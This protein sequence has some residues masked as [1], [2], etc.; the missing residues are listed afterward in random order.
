M[1]RATMS[2][3]ISR[4]RRMV[5]DTGTPNFSDDAIQDELDT[6]QTVVLYERLSTAPTM[7]NGVAQYLTFGSAYQ[8]FETGA[9]VYN[10]SYGVVTPTTANLIAGT[11]TFS[12]NQDSTMYVS[13]NA[14]NVFGAAANLCDQWAAQLS[15]S[16]DV[17]DG[18][19]EMKRSQMAKSLRDQ[20][21]QY[22]ASQGIL[23]STSERSDVRADA[24][25]YVAMENFY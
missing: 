19:S 13:G 15:R 3:L 17:K 1:P 12:S 22:R 6:F 2:A 5:G 9:V 7:V 18:E 16:F 25:D 4:L 24:T 14:Y 20:A 23:Q 21:N 11:W 8:N 10:S